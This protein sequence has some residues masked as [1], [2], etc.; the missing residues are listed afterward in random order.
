MIV[1]GLAVGWQG[2]P[3][4]LITRV[5]EVLYSVVEACDDWKVLQCEEILTV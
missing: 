4:F 3:I 5:V 1:Q 2:M